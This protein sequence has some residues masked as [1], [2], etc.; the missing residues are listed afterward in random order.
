MRHILGA[1]LAALMLA[2]CPFQAQT[3]RAEDD[4]SLYNGGVIILLHAEYHYYTGSGAYLT[5]VII[6]ADEEVEAL[7]D[8]LISEESVRYVHL[9]QSR[10]NMRLSTV[11]NQMLTGRLVSTGGSVMVV[12]P[13][14]AAAHHL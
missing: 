13:A 1:I 14:Y 3:A 12:T 7:N 10:L 6:A 8:R 9:D 4:G 5:L 11:S 2:L